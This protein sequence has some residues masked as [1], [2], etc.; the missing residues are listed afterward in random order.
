MSTDFRN[1]S[2]WHPDPLRHPVK[3]EFLVRVKG[4]LRQIME[5]KDFTVSRVWLH[6][7]FL[8]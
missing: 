4:I 6:G 2:L 1:E 8:L 3:R 7:D 5:L